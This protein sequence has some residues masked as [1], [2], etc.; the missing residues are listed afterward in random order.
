MFCVGHKAR[1][2]KKD[3]G[4]A[5]HKFHGNC[6]DRAEGAANAGKVAAVRAQHRAERRIA[7]LAALPTNKDRAKLIAE[8]RKQIS[9]IGQVDGKA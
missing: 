6:L 3:N 5:W 8:L 1:I 4:R 7:E 2:P 9:A